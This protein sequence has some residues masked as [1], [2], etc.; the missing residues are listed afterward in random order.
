MSDYEETNERT[1]TALVL[2]N[3]GAEVLGEY[4]SKCLAHEALS[5]KLMDSDLQSFSFRIRRVKEGVGVDRI[6]SGIMEKK[7]VI[8]SEYRDIEK[9]DDEENED[10]FDHISRHYGRD[11]EV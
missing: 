1:Y 10:V 4:P 7:A 5:E 8:R 3:G 6:W 9:E 2:I 11:I